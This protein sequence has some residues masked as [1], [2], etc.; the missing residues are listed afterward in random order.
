M[1]QPRVLLFKCIEIQVNEMLIA[2]DFYSATN[3]D[4]LQDKASISATLSNLISIFYL[5]MSC[6]VFVNRDKQIQKV[7]LL[8]YRVLCYIRL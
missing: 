2:I 8:F 4:F 5:R 6:P 7:K 3:E 1:Q